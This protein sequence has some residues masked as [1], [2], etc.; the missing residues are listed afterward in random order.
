MFCILL[1]ISVSYI[2]LLLCLCI[3][4]VTY[5]LFCTATLTEVF[6]AAVSSVVRQ[7]PGYNSQGGGA[8]RT[9]T[10]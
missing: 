3:L 6:R 4:I 9:V 8:A 7:M 2:F 5:A 1:L 10:N